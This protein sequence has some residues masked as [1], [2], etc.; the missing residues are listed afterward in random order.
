MQLVEQEPLWGRFGYSSKTFRERGEFDLGPLPSRYI[1][2][3][4]CHNCQSS[5]WC[6]RRV[7]SGHEGGG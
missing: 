5:H 6:T 1:L 3:A 2:I 7:H 4:R